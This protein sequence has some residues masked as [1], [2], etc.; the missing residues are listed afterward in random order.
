MNLEGYGPIAHS[1]GGASMAYD[2]GTAAVMNNPATLGLMDQGNRLDAALGFLG[3]NVT[4]QAP[5]APDAKSSADAFYMPAIGWVQKKN[6]LAYGVGM[7]SQGGM[8]TE[9]DANS[10]MA[11][12]TGKT[13]RSEVGVGRVIAPI[14]YD[15][16]PNINVGGSLDFVWAGM[17]LQMAMNGTQFFDLVGAHQFGEASGSLVNTLGGF[18]SA[19][20]GVNNAYFDF[21]DSSAF[22]G[23]ATGTGFAGKIG[24]T[25]K[26]S[27]Q[28]VI[29][30]TYHTKTSLSDLEASGANVTL[31]V[32]AVA[33]GGPASFPMALSGDIKVKDFQWPAT[34]AVGT[35]FK[36]ND[37]LMVVADIKLIQWADAMKNFKMSFTA[38]QSASNN[39]SAAFGGNPAADLRGQSMDATLYQDWK[40]QTVYEIGGAYKVTDAV[41]VRAGYNYGKNPIPD[42]YL[43]ALFPAIVENHITA[44]V[45]YDI[46]KSSGINFSLAYAPEVKQTN[47]QNQVTSTH[48]Q[49]NWQLMY[50]YL[51]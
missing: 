21:S 2:N 45:G 33:F 36:A 50:S 48:S 29:G 44:G 47:S 39:Y 5:G 3:P 34:F 16:N 35:A 37:K 28:W 20:L 38:D 15:V 24:G 4:A 31:N 1:M 6:K 40:D 25:F 41:T 19:G 51:F 12:G 42:Q 13:V 18:V 43:N 14:V 26:V 32:N 7:F 23:K 9:Y 46:S 17:D 27:P 22:T 8:G 30:A 10:F 11:A 49:F